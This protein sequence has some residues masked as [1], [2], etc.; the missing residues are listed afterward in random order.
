MTVALGFGGQCQE[1]LLESGAVC[2]AQLGE[3]DASRP[4]DA[5]D[6]L[7]VRVDA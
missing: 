3:G 7:C 2:C 1:H 5:S 4:G 6:H